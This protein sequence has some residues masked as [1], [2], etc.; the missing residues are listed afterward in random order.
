MARKTNRAR[1]ATGAKAAPSQDLGRHLYVSLPA[2]V[3]PKEMI[4]G[5]LA[6]DSLH[7]A[8]SL[9]DGTRRKVSVRGK[10]FRPN[11]YD[12]NRPLEEIY[13]EYVSHVKEILVLRNRLMLMA[14]RLGLGDE[15]PSVEVHT[16]WPR[17]A[18]KILEAMNVP[19]SQVEDQGGVSQMV[20]EDSLAGRQLAA[21][22]RSRK[23]I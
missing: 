12:L 19:E 8:M 18:S 14:I 10:D 22:K 13:V 9:G 4:E 21:I 15:V 16:T 6:I 7:I 3:V 20:D 5:R 2:D 23:P 11:L 1:T 17:L